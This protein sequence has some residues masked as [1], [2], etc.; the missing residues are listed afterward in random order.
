MNNLVGVQ[1]VPFKVLKKKF[2]E[3]FRRRRFFRMMKH[4]LL[5]FLPF[6]SNYPNLISLLDCSNMGPKRPRPF[7]VKKF[8]NFFES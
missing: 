3:P 6:K 2:L 8:S 1:T 4:L 7:C 5:K